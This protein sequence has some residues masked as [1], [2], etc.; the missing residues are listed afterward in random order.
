MNKRISK[1]KRIMEQECIDHVLI[2]DY[3][4][5]KYFINLELDSGER[6]L[7][8]L[9]NKDKENI[10]FINE[11]FSIPSSDDYKIIYYNDT[12]DCISILSSYLSGKSIYVDGKWTA[13]FLL[14]LMNRF[15][16][17]YQ[18][19]IF[20]TTKL[21]SIKDE[22]EI[23]FMIKA[24]LDND[25]VMRRIVPFIKIGISEKELYNQLLFEFENLTCEPVS[26][27]PIVAFG[28]NASNPH[29][30][31][32]D[33]IL[34]K[35]DVCLIDMGCR[36]Q[37]YCSDMTRT[38]LQK[39]EKMEEI[40]DIVKTANLL[41]IEAI[42]PGKKF[43]QIDKIARD[44]IISF[45]YGQYFTHRLGHGIGLEVHEGYDVSSSSEAIIEEGMCFSIEPGIYLPDIGGVRIE[46][47]VLVTEKGGI[48]LNSFSK[49]KTFI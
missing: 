8:L 47:L 28:K 10:L 6:L 48:V 23:K 21:R 9:I 13:S 24:S 27:E 41:A 18:D 44:Y 4:N 37:G 46:D 42:K 36:H 2:T 49:E 43:S 29:H 38:F 12:E 26:F 25:E 3:Y 20:L 5:L 7:A 19:A 35:G 15:S 16:A 11:L 33:T 22:Q 34:Q 45:G 32:N 39:N 31:S 30:Q 40:Y 1:I 17:N 14:R